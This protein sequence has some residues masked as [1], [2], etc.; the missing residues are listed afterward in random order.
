MPGRRLYFVYILASES[1]VLYTGITRDLLRRVGQHRSGVIPGF[2]RKY[3][4]T[5]L[6]W[7]EC[8]QNPTAAI[9]RE[10]Q[11]KGW[12]RSREVELIERQ[13]LGWLDQYDILWRAP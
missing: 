6:V 12:R 10:K 5:K 9:A 13:N 2:A 1:R 8:H 4:I 7:Y 11:I 3:R